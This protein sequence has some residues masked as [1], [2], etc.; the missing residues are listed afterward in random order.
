MIEAAKI[1]E[2]IALYGTSGKFTGRQEEAPWGLHDAL[3]AGI[4]QWHVQSADVRLKEKHVS[5]HVLAH[6][7]SAYRTLEIEYDTLWEQYLDFIVPRLGGATRRLYGIGGRVGD[8]IGTSTINNKGIK[9]LR[10]NWH[11]RS[12]WDPEVTLTSHQQT[13]ISPWYEDE[14]QFYDEITLNGS[15]KVKINQWVMSSDYV[16]GDEGCLSCPKV[17]WF[18]QVKSIFTHD[19][20]GEQ[21]AFFHVFWHRSISSSSAFCSDLQA[22]LVKKR[23]DHSKRCVVQVHNIIPLN[24]AIVDHPAIND[25]YVVITKSFHVLSSVGLHVPWPQLLKYFGN[26]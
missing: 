21:R 23:V 7:H 17:L 4:A 11:L 2:C 8:P 1:K 6:L 3:R 15:F 20:M 16:Q 9:L 18:G 26:H 12:S 5:F 14:L 24:L 25:C 13:I 10:L 19:W 22:P